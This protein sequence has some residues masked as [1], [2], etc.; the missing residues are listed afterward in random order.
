M[1]PFTRLPD[2]M[3]AGGLPAK[4]GGALPAGRRFRP[5]LGKVVGYLYLDGIGDPV[6]GI[7][8]MHDHSAGGP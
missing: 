7:A 3:F 8:G 6:L 5:L 4:D 2:H 1:I